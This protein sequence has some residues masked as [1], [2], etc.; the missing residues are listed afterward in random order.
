[1]ASC[2]RCWTRST[3]CLRTSGRAWRIPPGRRAR[4]P[5]DDPPGSLLRP[6][7]A[8]AGAAF[9]EGAVAGTGA[10]ARRALGEEWGGGLP[11]PVEFLR[12]PIGV[13]G[14]RPAGPPQPDTLP[15]PPP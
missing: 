15:P 3:W 10:P 2:W 6:G 1:M 7:G 9:R 14:A 13:E 5:A 11:G 8:A 4:D 12:R